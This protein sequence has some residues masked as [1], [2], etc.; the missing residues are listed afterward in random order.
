MASGT[1]MLSS[2]DRI[3]IE[4]DATLR[5]YKIVNCIEKWQTA[6]CQIPDDI[7]EADSE[8]YLSEA[9]SL[10]SILTNA[11]LHLEA[12]VVC[13]V[14][15]AAKNMKTR[16]MEEL[17][18]EINYLQSITLKETDD[19]NTDV[20]SDV[21][22][23]PSIEVVNRNQTELLIVPMSTAM[24]SH[25]DTITT[26]NNAT[27]VPVT[28]A[29][30]VNDEAIDFAL[31]GHD[32]T[33]IEMTEQIIPATEAST[34]YTD[35]MEE[36]NIALSA[37]DAHRF[38]QDH[39]I[40]T[41]SIGQLT[42]NTV[43]TEQNSI[44]MNSTSQEAELYTTKVP[45]AYPDLTEQ[46]SA[47]CHAVEAF[48]TAEGHSTKPLTQS[49]ITDSA[50]VT[51]YSAAHQ[52]ITHST[53]QPQIIPDVPSAQSYHTR[54]HRIQGNDTDCIAIPAQA[55]VLED[56]GPVLTVLTRKDAIT[57]NATNDTISLYQDCSTDDVC[58]MIKPISIVF[59]CCHSGYSSEILY[60][61]LYS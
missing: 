10:Q 61:L 36:H 5:F 21:T 53:S 30:T 13:E 24:D 35:S 60:I 50:L 41:D 11:Y 8:D 25:D 26:V 23:L 15:S 33:N 38:D 34:P 22:E 4:L 42:V 6:S 12:S 49:N 9:E 19:E 17:T 20:P 29:L 58:K 54:E 27:R 46:V 18:Y 2:E 57:M 51:S 14:S 3:D 40:E 44:D 45:D 39:N 16:L 55:N 56:S 43:T 28:P 47:E 7:Y 1:D 59:M 37:A 31:T 32:P 52:E 48:V